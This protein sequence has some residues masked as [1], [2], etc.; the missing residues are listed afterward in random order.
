MKVE[1]RKVAERRYA[2][3]IL[4]DRLPVL[5]MNPAPGFDELMPHDL[6]HLI[7]EQV[8]GIENAIFGQTAKG[9]GTFRIQPSE[10][11]NSKN[12]ARRRRK[13]IKKGKNS[14]KENLEDY[15]KSERATYVCWQYWLSKSADAE[16]RNRAAEMKKTADSIWGQMSASERAIYTE[17]TLEK[18]SQRMSELSRQWQNL[19]IGESMIVDWVL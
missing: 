18:V 19:K 13:T 14:V 10:A 8:L 2:V 16:L 6:C 7:V 1:F 12:D 5:E 9:T 17:E 11:S 3:R 15:A 4:R